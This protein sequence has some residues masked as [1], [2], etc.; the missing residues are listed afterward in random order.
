MFVPSRLLI[1]D[2]AVGPQWPALDG[3]VFLERDGL[4]LSGGLDEIDNVGDW[5]AALRRVCVFAEL[6]CVLVYKTPLGT[7]F[8]RTLFTDCKRLADA[9]GADATYD[10]KHRRQLPFAFNFSNRALPPTFSLWEDPSTPATLPVSDKGEDTLSSS[11]SVAP[12]IAPSTTTPLNRLRTPSTPDGGLAPG[13]HWRLVAYATPP[14]PSLLARRR[15]LARASLSILVGY[16]HAG[17]AATVP[18]PERLVAVAGG[19]RFGRGRRSRQGKEAER[20]AEVISVSASTPADGPTVLSVRLPSS[21][22]VD[23]VVGVSVHQE[24]RL[25]R[26]GNRSTVLRRVTVA[27][28]ATPGR[29]AVTADGGDSVRIELDGFGVEGKARWWRRG[30]ATT[31]ERSVQEFEPVEKPRMSVVTSSARSSTT[32]AV[33]EDEGESMLSAGKS[34]V[35]LPPSTPETL[36]QDFHVAIEVKYYAVV[37]IAG[38][39][40]RIEEMRIPFFLG[41]PD[42]PPE[43]STEPPPPVTNFTA[44]SVAPEGKGVDSQSTLI[45]PQTTLV[46]PDILAPRLASTLD[47]LDLALSG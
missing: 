15:P 38:A 35:H 18:L 32:V 7:T 24:V 47:D 19:P 36:G 3:F 45:P 28:L 23:R 26:P 10:G 30:K 4:A 14:T 29:V 5:D 31:A 33:K 25:L 40:K 22:G 16:A 39:G 8:E 21:V 2:T 42:P 20:A 34:F 1:H 11:A 46:T 44:N 9:P 43:P 17:L 12:S 41:S 13:I 27:S 37:R 6:Q